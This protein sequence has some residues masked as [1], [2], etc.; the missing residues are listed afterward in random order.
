GS[1]WLFGALY[2]AH[3][4][5]PAAVLAWPIA[6]ILLILDALS[7]AEISIMFPTANTLILLPYYTHGHL[8]SVIMSSFAWLSLASIP[9]IE[10][11]GLVQYAS[12][13]IPGLMG[14][15]GTRYIFTG[16]GYSTAMILLAS[17]VLLNYFGIRLFARIN[18]GFTIWKILIPTLTVLVLFQS[19]FDFHNFFNYGG[20]MPYGWHG[21]MLAMSSGGILF[22]LLGFRQVI[23]L[24]HET[25]HPE[26]T[27]PRVLIIS[28]V[29]T[30]FLYTALQAVFIGSL[31]PADLAQGWENLK[32]PG[33]AGPF[34][35]LATIAGMMWL[36]SVLYVDA[37]ISPYS[38]AF[39]YSATAAQMLGSMSVM[40]DAPKILAR[41][42]K[43]QIPYLSLLVNF[44]LG[45]ILFLILRSWQE[46]AAFS[47]ATVMLTYGVG[48]ICLISLRKQLPDYPRPFRL[49]GSSFIAFLGFYICTAGVYWAGVHSVIR[50]LVL[51]TIGMLFYFITHKKILDG[52][53][54][55]WIFVYLVSLGIFSICGNYG[56]KHFIPVYWDMLYLMGLCGIIFIF[57]LRSQ[58][59]NI[60]ERISEIRI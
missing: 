43:F 24:M 54:A 14:Q 29:L 53:N 26:K 8:T 30:T 58:K 46:M 44:I 21:V 33:D 47:V 31:H 22:S 51:I 32:F 6:G 15:H 49:Y 11:Q 7:F 19:H 20:F 52:K 2:S 17:F 18:E 41:Q 27:V 57:A 10:T 60:K 9:V 5:G 4:A 1:G 34:A 36:S 28:L 40:G 25:N 16:I 37:F 38:T 42:N 12:N 35:A 23:I 59:Q 56:G 13:Y 50:L 48:P 55:L 39:V 45:A 3:F